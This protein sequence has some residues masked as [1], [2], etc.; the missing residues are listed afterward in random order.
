MGMTDTILDE[1]EGECSIR[2]ED[3]LSGFND[4]RKNSQTG[5]YEVKLQII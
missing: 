2:K 5:G 3:I 1:V 4:K